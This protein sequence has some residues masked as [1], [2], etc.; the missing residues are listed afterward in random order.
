MQILQVSAEYFPLLKTG[1]LADVTG[2]L[3][4]ALRPLGCEL[5][6]LLPGFAEVL[7]GLHEP[8]EVGSCLTPWGQAVRV[9]RGELRDSGS[10]DDTQGPVAYVADS[11]ALYLRPGGPYETPD[12]R[13]H[14]DNH[15]RFAALAWVAARLA[16]GLD[17]SWRPEL[18]HGH[19][20][21]AGLVPACLAASGDRHVP[22]LFTIHNLAYQGLFPRS[23][24]QGLGLPADWFQIEGLEFHGQLSFMKAGLHYADRIS[25]VSPGYAR[26]IQTPEFGCGLDGLLR[27]RSA[28]LSGIL[29][30]IDD[31]VWD[32]RRDA[33]LQARYDADSLDR[34]ALNKAALQA[35]LGLEPRPELPLFTVVSRL[36]EQKG[37]PLVL[38]G[39]D[40]LVQRGAQLLLLGSGDSAL[41]AAFQAKAG[42]HPGR[43]AVRLGYDEALSHRIFGGGDVALV[44]SR[45]EPCGLTQMY[46]LAYGCVPLVR[47]VGGLADTVTDADLVTLVDGSA[48]GVVFERMDSADFGHAVQR[49]L[50]LYRRP[51][52]WRQVQQAGMRQ[53]LHWGDAAARYQALYRSMLPGR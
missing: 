21:H 26:E 24:Y 38:D 33:Q 49:M 25:T 45:F 39:T 9:L 19:D 53:P 43:V 17:P 27:H 23:D 44:P 52:D 28:V 48:T 6:T 12:K 11:A 16:R 13:P 31:R 1:G 51:A 14:P 41:E 29:N 20:W 47:R 3:P 40:A 35:E 30:G 4:R 7:R 22:S 42:Q 46:G 8:V 34:R 50:A 36:T 5:R 10:A 18:V 2:A 15:R 32:P 37:L